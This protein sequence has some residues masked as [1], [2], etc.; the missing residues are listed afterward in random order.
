MFKLLEETPTRFNVVDKKS[1][2]AAQTYVHHTKRPKSHTYFKVIRQKTITNV[3]EEK[4]NLSTKQNTKMIISF[5]QKNTTI[6]INTNYIFLILY[7]NTFMVLYTIYVLNYI[8]FTII[9]DKK[10]F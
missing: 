3:R 5:L 1:T 9:Y 6:S 8:M 4:E 7:H 2:T 10:S